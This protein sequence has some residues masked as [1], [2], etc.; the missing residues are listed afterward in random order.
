MHACQA[1]HHVDGGMQG[2]CLPFEAG[3][4]IIRD[5]AAHHT[6]LLTPGKTSGNAGACCCVWGGVHRNHWYPVHLE[7]RRA[8][9][10]CVGAVQSFVSYSPL[11]LRRPLTS[12]FNVRQVTLMALPSLESQRFQMPRHAYSSCSCDMLNARYT[13]CHH[14]RLQCI[15]IQSMSMPSSCCPHAKQCT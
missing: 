15:S 2:L 10:C 14:A 7:C 9:W 6:S 11:E 3:C 8:S 13:A 12:L 4:C 1:G 5:L